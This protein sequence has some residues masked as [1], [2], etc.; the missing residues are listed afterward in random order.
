VKDLEQWVCWRSE[1][2]GR[3]GKKTKVPYSPRSGYATDARVGTNPEQSPSIPTQ[4]T[5]PTQ[6]PGKQ[7][8][9]VR[10]SPYER[11]GLARRV[12]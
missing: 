11:E 12:A 8:T 5:Q 9:G 2:R 7:M 1:V 3:D 4:P 10:G 6:D